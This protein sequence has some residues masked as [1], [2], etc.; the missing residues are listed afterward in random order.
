[1]GTTILIVDDSPYIVDGLV[2]LLKRKG[3]STVTASGGEAALE[4]LKTT[5]PDLILLDIMMEPIDGW[6]TLQKIKADPS[7]RDIPV[8][9]F[10]AKKIT[11]EEAG[12]HSLSIEDFVT[13]PVN[14]AQLLE[15]IGRVFERRSAVKEEA[16]R[17]KD[18]GVDAGLIDEYA[19]LRKSIEVDTNLLQV[20]KKTR[21]TL[22]PGREADPEDLLAIR[23]L[24]EKIAVDEKRLS[25]ISGKFAP[26]T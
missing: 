17:A 20:L 9:M 13:K 26:Q 10:S 23:K 4:S 7:T 11:A 12:E 25:E 18:K 6:E 16:M 24:E 3:F 22:F 15:A 5:L 21:G 2:A 1:V 19:A 14:P 8:L